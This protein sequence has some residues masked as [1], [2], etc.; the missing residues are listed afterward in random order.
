MCGFALP[1]TGFHCCIG[2]STMDDDSAIIPSHECKRVVKHRPR[3][4]V[5]IS[6]LVRVEGAVNYSVLYF[7]DGSTLKIA[8]PIL[9][10]TDRLPEFIRIH[11]RH[12]INLS[13][14]AIHYR[15]KSAIRLTTGEE[16]PVG[17]R[18]KHQVRELIY[19]YKRKGLP[20][21]V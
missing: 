13:Y 17:R 8:M 21:L 7:K 2:M 19:L 16:L 3:V 12:L 15:Y 5:T 6:D 11:R 10:L 14:V 9:R 4:E 18:R 20:T 1:G